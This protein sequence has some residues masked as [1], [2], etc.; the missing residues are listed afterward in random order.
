MKLV[1]ALKKYFEA[2]GGRPVSMSEMKDFLSAITDSD[3]AE[4]VAWFN[5]QGVQV[6][7]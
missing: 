5:A 1:I 2:D 6:E 3:R 7:A 4:Y